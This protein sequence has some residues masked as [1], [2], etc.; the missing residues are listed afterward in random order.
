M[1][2]NSQIR[3]LPTGSSRHKNLELDACAVLISLMFRQVLHRLHMQSALNIGNTKGYKDRTH[4]EAVSRAACT[5][6]VSY[7][8]TPHWH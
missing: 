3:T 8:S 4:I 5:F 7:R 1:V 2:N 6:P